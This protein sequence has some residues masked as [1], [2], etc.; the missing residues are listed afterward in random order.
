MVTAIQFHDEDP[1]T[2]DK[3]SARTFVEIN[4][5][6]TSV[7]ATHIDAI[8]Y[9]ILGDT[10]PRAIA[11]QVIL[12]VNKRA[13]KA[14]YGMFSTNQT[15]FGLIQASTVLTELKSIT[16]LDKLGRLRTAQRGKR[17]NERRGY[18]QLYQVD[19]IDDLSDPERLIQQAMVCIERYFGFGCQDVLA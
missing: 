13:G 5:T 3:Y 18:E 19:D 4:S 17:L 2:I 16:S 15:S 11:A 12:R 6:Q 8:A 1:D 7:H 10:Y 14:L 9:T